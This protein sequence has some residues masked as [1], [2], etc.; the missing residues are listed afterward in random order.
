M[1][2]HP[3]RRTVLRAAGATAATAA[4]AGTLAAC[5]GSPTATG[6]ATSTIQAADIPVGGGKV[7]GQ[8]VVT[9]PSAGTYKAFSAICTHQSCTVSK[10]A[11]SQIVCPCHNSVFDAATGAVV[12]GPATAPLP[13]KTVTLSAGSLTVG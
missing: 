6:G 4:T 11:N 9:Q 2:T 1:A 7:V 5:G 13:A 12:S 8:V 3:S 10:V